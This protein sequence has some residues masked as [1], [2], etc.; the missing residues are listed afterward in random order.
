MTA[1]EDR[2]CD[3]TALATVAGK[4]TISVVSNKPIGGTS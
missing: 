3:G 4:N 2:K 1:F